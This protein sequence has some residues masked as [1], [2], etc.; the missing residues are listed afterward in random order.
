[1]SR[2]KYLF[3]F[4]VFFG[5]FAVSKFRVELPPTIGELNTLRKLMLAGNKLTSIPNELSKCRELE[6][7]RIADNKLERLPPWVFE[8]PRLSWFAF[9]GNPFEQP[10]SAPTRAVTNIVWSDLNIGERIGEGASGYVHKALLRTARGG[11]AEV[12]VKL[13][14]GETTSDGLPEY[15]MEVLLHQRQMRYCIACVR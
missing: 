15:E 12:A 2:D 6:L 9:A 1:M 13:F 4:E 14:K 10:T 8:M 5:H 3:Y 11:S 7:L